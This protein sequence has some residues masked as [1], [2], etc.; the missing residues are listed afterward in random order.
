[1]TRC[2]LLPYPSEKKHIN[3]SLCGVL[4]WKRNITFKEIQPMNRYDRYYALCY[5]I[6]YYIETSTQPSPVSLA[7]LVNWDAR[8]TVPYP[9]VSRKV[10]MCPLEHPVCC[11]SIRLVLSKPPWQLS[12]NP[13]KEGMHQPSIQLSQASLTIPA[14]LL[15]D[16]WTSW[17]ANLTF[18]L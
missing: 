4:S 17:G 11:K 16:T 9:G 15:R 2:S 12:Q 13:N 1:M 5:I 3:W 7:T 18:G 6:I 10:H 8:M 14:P